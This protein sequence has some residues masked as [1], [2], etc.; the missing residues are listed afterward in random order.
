MVAGYA[1]TIAADRFGTTDLDS[2]TE[3][4]LTQLRNTLADRLVINRHQGTAATRAQR[5][6]TSRRRQSTPRRG[7][8]AVL[9]NNPF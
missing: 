9:S 2:L 3:L 7:K 6:S 5:Q 4:Q 1:A 8:D